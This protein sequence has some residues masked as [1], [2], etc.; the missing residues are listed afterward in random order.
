MARLTTKFVENVKPAA[1]RREIPDTGCRGLYLIV[2]PTGRKA[3]AVRY[4]FEGATRKLTLDTGLTLAAARKAATA[5]LHELETGNDPAAARAEAK[6]NAAAAKADTV[7]A[8][9]EDYLRREG[10]KLR[11]VDQ[12]VSILKRLVYPVI[13]DRP[14][15]GLKRSDIVRLLDRIEDGQGQ[16]AADVTLSVL[17]RIFNWHTL[18]SD[19]F[20]PPIVPGMGRQNA[21]DHRRTRIL[22]D[23]ELRRVWLASTAEDAQPFGALIR[24]LLLTAARRSEAAGM[25]W[26]EVEANGVWTLPARRSKNKTDVPRPL[27]QAAQALLNAQPRYSGCEYVFTNNGAAAIQSFSG[28]KKRLDNVSGV[29]G[30]RLHDLR[31]TARSLLSRAGIHP[32]L[33]ERCLGHAIGGVRGVYD[34]HQY[35][36]EMRHAFEALAA[37]IARLVSG[38]P[39]GVVP[40]RIGR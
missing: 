10:H 5:A 27:C 34:R 25:R 17:R 38:T 12:S 18:R 29:T 33:A 40:I 3:W 8:I 24:F 36:D 23:D 30:W 35:V 9:C 4:R 2:Q 21:R 26:N 19:S 6:V 32:D 37:L 31:R 13:G 1:V 28:A 15:E 16:R 22:N 14:V 39:A 7:A 11:T 20:I